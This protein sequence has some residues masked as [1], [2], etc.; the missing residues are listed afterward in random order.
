M[1]TSETTSEPKKAGQKPSTVNPIP[2]YCPMSPD[3]QKRR[4]LM[5]K[6]NRP[7]VRTT[8]ARKLNGL[9]SE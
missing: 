2:K 5:S 9:P 6:M 3:T 4:V 8:Q 7:R 1:L